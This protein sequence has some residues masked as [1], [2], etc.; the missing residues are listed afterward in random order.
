MF[1]F[2]IR[3]C[4]SL[5][6]LLLYLVINSEAGSYDQGSEELALLIVGRRGRMGNV[7]P[8]WLLFRRERDDHS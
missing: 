1:V 8:G 6:Y 2:P 7:L 3:E 5:V 4:V